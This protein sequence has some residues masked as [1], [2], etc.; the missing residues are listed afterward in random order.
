MYNFDDPGLATRHV[1][2][3]PHVDMT[4]GLLEPRGVVARHDS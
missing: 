4:T 1:E 3:K 2:D